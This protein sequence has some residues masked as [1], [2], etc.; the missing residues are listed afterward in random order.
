MMNMTTMM[1]MVLT[2]TKG[3]GIVLFLV[4]DMILNCHTYLYFP[5]EPGAEVSGEKSKPK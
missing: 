4:Q 5:G 3:Q 1:T 2:L